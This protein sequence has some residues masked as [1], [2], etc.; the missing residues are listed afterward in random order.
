M[1]QRDR[2]EKGWQWFSED[3]QKLIKKKQLQ[4]QT[5]I[6][7]NFNDITTVIATT[8]LAFGMILLGLHLLF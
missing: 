2:A 3:L 4:K 7:F 5:T 8:L 6:K 1:I